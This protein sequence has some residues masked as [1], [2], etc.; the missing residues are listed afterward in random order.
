[1]GIWFLMFILN[2][3]IPLIMVIIG[4]LFKFKPP[5]KINSVYG[6]RT[7]MSM[8]NQETWRFSHHHSG[9]VFSILGIV[10]LIV[11]VLF[12]LQLK[13][14]SQDAIGNGATVL[15]VCQLIVIVAAIFPT[16]R[17]LRKTFD[18]EGNRKKEEKTP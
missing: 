17:A 10:S 7:A 9:N 15:I 13:G 3:Q 16:E 18:A 2:L 11:S 4:L 6:Y 8:K 12:L 14:L 1:M 5:Q